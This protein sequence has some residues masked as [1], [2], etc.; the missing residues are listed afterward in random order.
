MHAAVVTSFD[1][2][3]RYLDHPEPVARG[4]DEVVV[5]VLAAGLHPRVRSQANGSHYTSTDELPLV[6]GIDAV[7][8]DPQGRLRYTVLDDT[9]LGTMAERTVIEL[10]RS[11]VLPDGRRPRSARGRH[12]PGDVVVGGVAPP[13]RL[14]APAARARPRRH[15]QRRPDGDPGGQALRRVTGD[16]GRPRP[17]PPRRPAGSGRGPDVHL[18]RTSRRRPMSTWSS[19]TSGASPRPG[20]WSTCSPPGPTAASH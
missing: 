12:E 8:R 6:P 20:P 13:D 14:Q 19:T 5:D 1:A 10:D 9:A 18:R 11:V 3:P 15:R 4:R 16:R 7:V 17:G 2:P